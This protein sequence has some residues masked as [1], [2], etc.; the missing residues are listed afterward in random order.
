[1]NFLPSHLHEYERQAILDFAAQLQDY[2]DGALCNL[3]LFGSKA[4]GDFTADSDL[5]LLIVV[6]ALNDKQRGII[7]RM[8][9]RVSLNHNTLINTHIL[10]KNRWEVIEQ[11]QDTLWRE[12]QRDGIPLQ[13]FAGQLTS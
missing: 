4:R 12:V 5:D 13:D 10:D 2:L 6:K 1:M 9:A 3:W 7:R 11:Y 8:A